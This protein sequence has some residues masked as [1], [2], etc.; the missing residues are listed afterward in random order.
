LT[1]LAARRGATRHGG[2]TNSIGVG[3][4][5]ANVTFQSNLVVE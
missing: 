4:T 3:A 1:R 5:P 2:W